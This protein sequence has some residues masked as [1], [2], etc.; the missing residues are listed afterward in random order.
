[1][2]TQASARTAREAAATQEAQAA[3][4]ALAEATKRAEQMAT[5]EDKADATLL[6]FDDDEDKGLAFLQHHCHQTAMSTTTKKFWM[7]L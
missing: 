1:M 6:F 3:D 5:E 7:L 4:E 2:V